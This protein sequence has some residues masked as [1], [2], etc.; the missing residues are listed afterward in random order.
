MPS[1]IAQLIAG[2]MISALILFLMGCGAIGPGTARVDH[3]TVS[4]VQVAAVQV[5]TI[6]DYVEAVGTV[7]SVN[8]SMI[9]T[10]VMSTVREVRVQEGDHVRAGQ[11]LMLLDDRDA[12]A[13][14]SKAQAG[15][16]EIQHAL[17]EVDEGIR[18]AD[19]NRALATATY[20]RF[21]DLLSKKSVSPQEFDEVEAKYRGAE[22]MYQSMLAK[23]EQVL[24]KG[25]QVNADIAAANTFESYTRIT[26]PQN[27]V[28]T[29]RSVD[30]GTM[31]TPGMPLVVVEDASRFRLEASVGEEVAS[32][33]HTGED[34]RITVD[35]VGVNALPAR[36]SEI[37]PATDP[38]SRTSIVKIDLPPNTQLRSGLFGTVQIPRGNRT[39]IFVPASSRFVRGE[40]EYLMV[41][42]ADQIA[43]M[44][45]V[46]TAPA[47]K[48]QYEIV[49]GLAPNERI[50]VNGADRVIDGSK[51]I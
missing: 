13:Q 2:L 47:G 31:A 32:T 42:N 17:T 46:K 10:K 41:V 37:V 15:R 44:R 45:L 29:Q 4:G 14:L 19:A 7:R 36:I 1:R 39:G 26:S 33:L 49:S 35:A 18:G 24:A 38:M 20:G 34:V 9:A 3:P 51:I 40:L 6:P 8:T 48:N 28:V 27:G 16:S 22:A 50:I 5:E 30:V 11:L 43:Q 25:Q 23:K 12:A 21:K